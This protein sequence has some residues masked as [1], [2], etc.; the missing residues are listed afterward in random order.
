MA[1]DLGLHCL[2]RSVSTKWDGTHGLHHRKMSSGLCGQQRSRSDWAGVITGYYRM[3]AWTA[4]A[5][6]VYFEHVQDDL[7][8]PILCKFKGTFFAL[9]GRHNV[10]ANSKG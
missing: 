5:L 10:E 8:L 2:L 6:M 7:N 9:C 3:Y 4:K 1:S